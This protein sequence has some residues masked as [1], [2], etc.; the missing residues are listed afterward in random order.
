MPGLIRSR[1]SGETGHQH[2]RTQES[3]LSQDGTRNPFVCYC[4]IP[5]L[6]CLQA[7]SAQDSER[8]SCWCK[9]ACKHPAR[10]SASQPTQQGWNVQQ[11]PAKALA[12]S[13]CTD[14][15]WRCANSHAACV[16]PGGRRVVSTGKWTVVLFVES[17]TTR[18]W[19]TWVSV[20]S[21]TVILKEL[22]WW[23]AQNDLEQDPRCYHLPGVDADHCRVTHRVSHFTDRR[24]TT[25]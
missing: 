6:I 11:R 17:Q 14:T 7:A 18:G 2:A 10:C 23:C 15:L 16:T 4:R 1:L 22:T 5:V 13:T 8:V 19:A 3:M 25:D 12:L 21:I 24:V 9:W 20:T